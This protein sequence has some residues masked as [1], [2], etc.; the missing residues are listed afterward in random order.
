MSFFSLSLL[1]NVARLWIV[2]FKIVISIFLDSYCKLDY[3][4]FKF[5]FISN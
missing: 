2:G 5:R 3:N 4:F 1:P